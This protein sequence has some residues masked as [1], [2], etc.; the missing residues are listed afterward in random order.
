MR[1]AIPFAIL[2]FLTAPAFS[3][4]PGQGFIPVPG[5]PV[6]YKVTGTGDGLPLLVLHGGPGL[7]L[8][9]I[10]E[11]TLSLIHISEPTRLC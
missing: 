6:W 10:S 11:P 2:L 7:S 5:G 4:A 3:Q 1:R 8:I 9:H